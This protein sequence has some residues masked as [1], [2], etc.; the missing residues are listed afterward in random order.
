MSYD[1]R[2]CPRMTDLMQ[3]Q[4]CGLPGH[5]P[6]DE[7]KS[8]IVESMETNGPDNTDDWPSV[9]MKPADVLRVGILRAVK[10]SRTKGI[11]A[12]EAVLFA[13]ARS[14]QQSGEEGASALRQLRESAI[15]VETVQ[16]VRHFETGAAEVLD[17]D[18][19]GWE[20]AHDFHLQ[21]PEEGGREWRDN[22]GDDGDRVQVFT[23][24]QGST[25][26]LKVLGEVSSSH[27]KSHISSLCGY[28][29][30]WEEFDLWHMWHPMV[31]GDGPVPV[32]PQD[33]DEN[34]LE[35][36]TTLQCPQERSAEVLRDT[37]FFLPE[38]GLFYQT[39]ETID[40]NE[41]EAQREP[42]K[43]FNR[44]TEKTCR[45]NLVLCQG[46]SI[47]IVVT[48]KTELPAIPQR[49]VVDLVAQWFVPQAAGSMFKFGR[50]A[51]LSGPH[52]QRIRADRFGLYA[53]L[54]KVAA[55]GP[56]CERRRGVKYRLGSNDGMMGLPDPAL[57]RNREGSLVA[58][59]R[60]L[61]SYL[62]I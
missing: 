12:A 18:M 30:M 20:A 62:R 22:I 29:A 28:V 14:L 24:Q 57:I 17:S 53:A 21:Y 1:R 5:R 39:H 4:C 56:A 48:I 23:R 44:P 26:E 6:D 34:V 52:F 55:A 58:F 47:A 2:L 35:L 27:G 50:Q 36:C 54:E 41:E 31:A 8:S 59:E 61:N 60:L 45:R 13:A 49:W 40:D 33:R 16:K 11:L 51:M 7:S 10:A 46:T 15:Y 3:L 42:P 43:G 38:E 37:V 25:L 9:Q 32:H 19:S